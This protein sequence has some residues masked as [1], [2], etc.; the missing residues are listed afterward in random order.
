MSNGKVTL[1]DIFEI[2]SRIEAK[3]DKC[4]LDCNPS[5]PSQVDTPFQKTSAGS[6]FVTYVSSEGIGNIAIQVTLPE[7]PRYDDGAPLLVYVSTFFTPQQP[8]FDT[9]FLDI[10]KLGLII[11]DLQMD[12]MAGLAIY[13]AYHLNCVREVIVIISIMNLIIIIII[14]FFCY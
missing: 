9:S 13:Y 8:A 10:T 6:S 1:H 3:L 5:L 11:A 7:T 12:P 4:S 14:C 2:N